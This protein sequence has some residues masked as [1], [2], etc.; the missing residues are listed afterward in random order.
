MADAKK[1]G[2]FPGWDW[3][4]SVGRNQGKQAKSYRQNEYSVYYLLSMAD[5]SLLGTKPRRRKNKT[6]LEERDGTEA[7]FL[8]C[9][10]WPHER[11]LEIF[12]QQ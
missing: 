3:F 4:S 7:P 6:L 9:E 10:G 5:F 2:I 12:A 1:D 11:S 8:G